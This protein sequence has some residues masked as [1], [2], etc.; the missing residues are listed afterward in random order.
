[1]LTR[2]LGIDIIVLRFTKKG[3]KQ[4]M[5]KADI[6]YPELRKFIKSK[7]TF[8]DYAKNVLHLSYMT[9]VYKFDKKIAFTLDDVKATK[10]YFKLSAN[11][12]ILFFFK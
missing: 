5:K 12:V 9:L 1:M 8:G 7:M 3:H 6:N 11:Q 10:D 2:Y 4:R